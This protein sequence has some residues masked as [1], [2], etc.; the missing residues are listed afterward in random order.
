MWRK[1]DIC[2]CLFKFSRIKSQTINVSR[3]HVIHFY[4]TYYQ[5]IILKFKKLKIN[6]DVDDVVFYQHEKFQLVIPYILGS[7][8]IT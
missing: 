5:N 4:K 7:P 8:K 1:N 3:L 6:P 2:L